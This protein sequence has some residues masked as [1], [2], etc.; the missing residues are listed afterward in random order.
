MKY[1]YGVIFLSF[2]AWAQQSSPVLDP[3]KYTVC[4]ITINSDD[5]KKVF[6]AQIKKHPNKFNPIV[7]LTDFNGGSDWFKKSCESGIKCD[8]LV[9]SGHFGGDFFSEKGD[10]NL[11]LKELEA[12]SCNKSCE[13]VLKNPLEVFLFGC[14]TLSNKDEDSRTPAQYL[15]V[16]LRDGIPLA[17]AEM[18]VESRYGSIGDSHRGTMQRIFSGEKKQIY[19]FDSIGPSGKNVKGFLNNYFAQ[20]SAP[21]RLELLESKRLM[22][23]VDLTNKT[24]ANSLKTT[25]FTQCAAGDAN[26]PVTKN[27]CDLQDENI[28][29]EKRLDLIHSL[30]AQENYLGYLPAINTFFTTHD[31][32]S[33]TEVEKKELALIAENKIIK[34]QIV[35]LINKTKSIGLKSE[36]SSF[37]ANVGFIT[38][39]EQL[40]I[41]KA[42]VTSAFDKKLTEDMLNIF[43]SLNYNVKEKLNITFSDIKYKDW[44]NNELYALSCLEVKDKAIAEHVANRVKLQKD[45]WGILASADFIYSNKN[46]LPNL[47]PTAI[48][49][50]KSLMAS[51]DPNINY[52]PLRVLAT[53]APNDPTLQSRIQSLMISP[54]EENQQSAIKAC[55]EME[56]VNPRHFK[57]I[58]YI[59]KSAK[60]PY[61][62]NTAMG[63]LL[64]KK[65]NDPQVINELQAM[66]QSKELEDYDKARIKDFLEQIK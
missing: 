42:S 43:C 29:V 44:G 59:L 24:L 52:S 3:N 41:V 61:T 21:K 15:Q 2:S 63:Y 7:E 1:F 18:V 55:T 14:N 58:L 50:F 5:E 49:K 51:N 48:A 30:M 19:G 22:D 47:D 65:V 11:Q 56:V 53:Y 46:L 27:L 9:I 10:K 64:A 36:W 16:L 66:L 35:G 33:F 31:P 54:N 25:A 26:D 38:P 57:P 34:D 40:K 8:Q 13:G 28:S 12:A 37:A 23:K 6:D 60:D 45:Q 32:K 62:R 39:E 20:V 4:A 17:R